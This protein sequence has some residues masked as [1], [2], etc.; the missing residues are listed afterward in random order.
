MSR[1]GGALRKCSNSVVSKD[2]Q[3]SWGGT[4]LYLEVMVEGTMEG[5]PSSPVVG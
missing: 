1:R 3:E 2:V 4:S 5:E